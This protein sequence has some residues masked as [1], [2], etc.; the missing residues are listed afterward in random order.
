MKKI[1]LT[2]VLISFIICNNL[3]SQSEEMNCTPYLEQQS[4]P[5]GL[6]G[7]LYLPAWGTINVLFVFAQF[8]DDKYDTLNTSWPKGQPPSNMQSWVDQTWSDN[9]AQGSMTHYFN[10]MSFNKLKFIGKTVSVITP[11]TRAWYLANNKKL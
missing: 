10:D 9:P 11:Q 3:Y 4:R 1:I 2:T 8:P 6:V 7:G 5:A